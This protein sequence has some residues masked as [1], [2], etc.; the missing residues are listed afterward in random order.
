MVLMPEKFIKTKPSFL[1]AGLPCASLSAECQR[2]NN[3]RQR[4]PQ[5]R[6]HIWWARRAPTVCR[7][8]VLSSLIPYDL[9][10]DDSLLPQWLPEPS[11]D[12]LNGLPRRIAGHKSFFEELIDAV[13]PT[14]LTPRHRNLL[15]AM[16]ITGDGH[17]AY[18][19]MALRDERAVG[20]QKISLPDCL[21]YRHIPAFGF[22]PSADLIR[23]IADRSRANLGLAVGP[24][25]VLDFMAGG[26]SIPLEA[27]RFGFKVFANDL[28]PVS[29]LVLKATLEYPTRLGRKLQPALQRFARDIN[30]TVRNRL[31]KFFTAE[32]ATDWWKAIDQSE[33]ARLKTKQVVKA[34][35]GGDA[36]TR[37]YLWLR[38]LPCPKCQLNIPLSTNF[39]IIKPKKSKTQLPLG[40]FPEVP[41]REQGNDC[42][43][44]MVWPQDWSN[45]KWP[46]SGFERWHPNGDAPP[47]GKPR[48]D[49]LTFQ[50]G[51]ATC[52]RCGT[53]IAEDKVKEYARTRVGGLP[54]Q[55]YAVCSQVPVRLTY[56]NGDVKTRYLWRF[57]PPTT[58]DLAAVS[59][60][61]KELQSLEA[62][63]AALIPTEDIPEGDKTSNVK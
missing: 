59:A 11:K 22:S 48:C 34:E 5:N 37:D 58:A 13:Q 30:E 24:L 14:P 21:V 2:D 17:A 42:T 31:A 49:G 54:S 56:K 50:D 51:K 63:L 46:R 8:A 26:G 18:R 43:F 41:T 27:V 36:I 60:A 53:V 3:A 45:C 28:N 6:L 4:P 9:D 40:A 39:H 19:R 61:E 25:I 16:G 57:R 12:E 7:V 20:G 35:P 1:E 29:A 55:M 33:L 44:R 62:R 52:P 23:Y 47:N 15:R 38:I 10:I 32:S